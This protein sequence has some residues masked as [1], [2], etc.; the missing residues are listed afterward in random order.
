MGMV[1]ATFMM[2]T[3][4]MGKETQLY[5]GAVRWGLL[6][7]GAAAF[8]DMFMAWWEGQDNIARVGYGTTGGNYTDAYR[9]INDYA[10][11][12]D[13]MIKRHLRVGYVCLLCL[14]VV[15]GVGLQQA[16]GWKQKNWQRLRFE[17][18]Q[19]SRRQ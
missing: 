2:S 18:R 8:M 6:F 1:L 3:F 10:W 9:L 13:D 12:W 5:K 11:R 16:W 14:C 7:W 17:A 19:A 15:Y 4:Y